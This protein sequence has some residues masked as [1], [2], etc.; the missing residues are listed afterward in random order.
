[1][2][3]VNRHR[4][5]ALLL[6]LLIS[7]AAFSLHITTHIS[8]DLV[9]CDLCVGHASPFSLLPVAVSQLLVVAPIFRIAIYPLPA[10][11]KTA[12]VLPYHQRAPPVSA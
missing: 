3:S 9:N 8:A 4:C 2:R 12:E 11:T 7:Y 5:Y 10:A 6:I 1:M